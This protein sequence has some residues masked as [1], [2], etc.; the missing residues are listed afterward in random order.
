MKAVEV[1]ITRF[2]DEWQPGWVECIL[3]DAMGKSHAFEEKV[4]M[5]TAEDLWSDS[6]YPRSGVIACEVEA[7]WE[8]ESGRSVARIDTEGPWAVESTTGET[9]FVVL[10]S[11]LVDL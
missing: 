1:S 6:D 4:P 9:H 7:E 2:V 3:V 5:V 11:Q 8:D 10:A